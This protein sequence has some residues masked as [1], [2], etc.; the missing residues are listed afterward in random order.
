[1]AQE[2]SVEDTDRGTSSKGKGGALC[3]NEISG[4]VFDRRRSCPHKKLSQEV[5]S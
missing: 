5:Y 4:I 3:K 1:M 2:P